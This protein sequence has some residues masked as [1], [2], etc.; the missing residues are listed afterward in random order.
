MAIEQ[1][2]G[3]RVNYNQR[4]F[5]AG[6]GKPNSLGAVKELVVDFEYDSLPSAGAVGDAVVPVLPVGAVVKSCYLL[7]K[8]AFVGGVGSA[9]SVG[10]AKAVDGTEL[11]LDGLVTAADAGADIA[12]IDADRDVVVGAGAQVN[13]ALAEAG[14]LVVTAS[15]AALTAGSAR[16]VVEYY[17]VV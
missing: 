2:N 8:S 16:I 9:L 1:V 14:K 15:G 13:K 7:V 6:A 11:D 4:E 10:T 17:E 3:V 5:H 12:H